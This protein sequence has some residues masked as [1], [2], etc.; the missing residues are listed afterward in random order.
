MLPTAIG[1]TRLTKKL[2]RLMSQRPSQLDIMK[3]NSTKCGSRKTGQHQVFAITS[4]LILSGW[5]RAK[6]RPIGP[7]QSVRKRVMF[8]RSRCSSSAQNRSAWGLRSV[9]GAVAAAGRQPKADVVRRD[10]AK[11]RPQAVYQV[12]ELERPRRIAVDEDDRLACAFVHVVHRMPRGRGEEPA[13]E[14]VQLRRNPSQDGSLA[15]TGSWDLHRALGAT[16]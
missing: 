3:L 11:F 7:P 10:A 1:M 14:R 16:P 15:W 6:C 9:I 2:N 13:L 12:P 8:R 5:V 4:R